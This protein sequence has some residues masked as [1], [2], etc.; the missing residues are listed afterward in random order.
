MR[1]LIRAGDA[2]KPLPERMVPRYFWPTEHRHTPSHCG[3]C[4]ARLLLGEVPTAD[5]PIADQT[6]LACGR[7]ACELVLDG[8]REQRRQRTGR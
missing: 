3:H 1:T 7:T 8:L 2:G 5:S 4:G 6:C